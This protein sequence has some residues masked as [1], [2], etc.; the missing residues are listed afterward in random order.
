[1]ERALQMIS[2]ALREEKMS[3]NSI[4]TQSLIAS[5]GYLNVDQNQDTSA[6]SSLSP[7]S[8]YSESSGISTGAAPTSI[9][10]VGILLS[11]LSSLEKKDPEA[12]Q[13]RAAQIAQDFH[14][15]AEQCTDTLQRYSLET[16]AEQF[17]NAALS[18]SMS[19]I[20]M[21]ATA[22]TLARA[23]TSQSSLTLLDYMNGSQGADF[24]GQLTSIMTANLS[25]KL[26]GVSR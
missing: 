19:S 18:G 1:M 12:F 25:S 24:S 20:N 22:T 3:V 7:V 17:S 21:G 16:M 14:D 26:N 5:L 6:T 13:E 9:S 4:T 2:Y 15:A 10:Q 11:N 23:Y 8:A